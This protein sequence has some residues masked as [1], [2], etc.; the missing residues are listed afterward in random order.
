MSGQTSTTVM[1]ETSIQ[2]MPGLND[3][4]YIAV[5][6]DVVNGFSHFL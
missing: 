2:E 3:F 1:P 5:L 6:M 4:L